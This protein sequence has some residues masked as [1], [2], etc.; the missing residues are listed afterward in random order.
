MPNFI[1]P[2]L[3]PGNDEQYIN[4]VLIVTN[5]AAEISASENPMAWF[6]ESLNIGAPLAAQMNVQVL[7]GNPPNGSIFRIIPANIS[8]SGGFPAIELVGSNT[9]NFGEFDTSGPPATV[10]DS[11]ANVLNNDIV[12]NRLFFADS[13]TAPGTII[14]NALNTG[15]RYTMLFEGAAAF[16]V[17]LNTVGADANIGQAN[18]DFAVFVQV[19]VKGS[20]NFGDEINKGTLQRV[21]EI[22][23]NYQAD[24]VHKF[25]VAGVVKNYL[26]ADIPQNAA[27]FKSENHIN[28]YCL[29]F[30]Y[31]YKDDNNTIKK[32]VSG[33]TALKWAQLAAVDLLQTNDLNDYVC[34]P[35]SSQKL[36]L[37]NQP[38]VKDYWLGQKDYVNI[39]WENTPSVPNIAIL[40]IRPYFYDGTIGAWQ[41]AGILFPNGGV[42][43]LGLSALPIS[44]IESTAGALIK[45]FDLRL[46]GALSLNPGDLTPITRIYKYVIRR[47][48]PERTLDFVFLNP[49]GGWD[50]LR[51][52]KRNDV[53]L[54]REAQGF[55]K[56]R[57]YLPTPTDTIR[58]VKG[59]T[60][61]RVESWSTGWLP[62]SHRLWLE[63]FAQSPAVY[64][65]QQNTFRLV[66][67]DNIRIEFDDEADKF[68]L[69]TDFITS[70][71]LNSINQ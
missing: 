46:K 42:Y 21:A 24:N 29:L 49:L 39:L 36:F 50:G 63:G 12:F 58:G 62:Q 19:F 45:Q 53:N 64:I 31:S 59:V 70:A 23:K 18:Q 41:D 52:T 67:L 15:S 8:F 48:C 10:A 66:L 17:T 7:T 11:I 26:R 37:S 55:E 40:E 28:N 61:E 51:M 5:E 14:I 13:I 35:P 22:T 20:G 71:P 32:I 65:F 3:L 43:S 1:P 6:F 34:T 30:G 69:T 16:S 56:S 33:V 25:D 27:Q 57:P 44:S 54:T 60:S 47:E 68:N 38:L 9:P 2:A 4:P